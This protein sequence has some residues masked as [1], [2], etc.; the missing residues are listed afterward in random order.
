MLQFPADCLV[1]PHREHSDA[2]VSKL[3]SDNAYYS[4]LD[5]LPSEFLTHLFLLYKDLESTTKK[6]FKSLSWIKSSLCESLTSSS[7]HLNPV[8]N[9]KIEENIF[10]VKQMFKRT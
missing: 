10:C 7:I 6:L 3:F 5:F 9:S 1:L 4:I 2:D 8:M